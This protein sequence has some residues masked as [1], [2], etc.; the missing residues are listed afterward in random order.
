MTVCLE[1]KP[2]FSKQTKKGER[3]L[4]KNAIYSRIENGKRRFLENFPI[5]ICQEY[6]FRGKDNRA[7]LLQDAI[8]R[9][10]VLV[11]KGD[12]RTYA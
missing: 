2:I 10:L 3:F 5:W 11:R 4:E 8:K 12:R 9:S 6:E 1:K 7:E